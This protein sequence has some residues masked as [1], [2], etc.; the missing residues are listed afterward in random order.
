MKHSTVYIFRV[1]NILLIC[2]YLK[3]WP[4]CYK[5]RLVNR[6]LTIKMLSDMS[7]G[8]QMKVWSSH[9]LCK[10]QTNTRL[11]RDEQQ[12]SPQIGCCQLESAAPPLLLV[13]VFCS[14]LWTKLNS[15]CVL[16]GYAH[17]KICLFITSHIVI[18]IL[19]SVIARCTFSWYIAGLVQVF[20]H[21]A[22]WHPH[23]QCRASTVTFLWLHPVSRVPAWFW[24]WQ[25]HK[26][27]AFCLHHKTV[28]HEKVRPHDRLVLFSLLSYHCVLQ[29]VE[30]CFP[31]P[32]SWWLLLWYLM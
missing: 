7:V 20:W 12:R 13:F 18:T 10:V 26:N 9:L 8:A 2:D 29:P 3:W 23:Q 5:N 31:S 22:V 6:L 24:C 27:K 11:R 4:N 15:P 19:N 32:V 25:N 30:N 1:I 16:Y 21:A 17:L 28:V 14:P